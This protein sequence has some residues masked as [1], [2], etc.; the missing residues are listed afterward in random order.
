MQMPA[1]APQPKM[2]YQ[3]PEQAGSID[4]NGVQIEADKQFQIYIGQ[5]PRGSTEQELRETFQVCG[6]IKNVFLRAEQQFGFVN[7]LRKEGAMNAM[8]QR[9]FVI[10]GSKLTL[11]GFHKKLQIILR[12]IPPKIMDELKFQQ[13]LSRFLNKKHPDLFVYSQLQAAK[14]GASAYLH[15]ISKEDSI[16][17]FEA[18]KS[19]EFTRY[20]AKE[21]SLVNNLDNLIL[22][23]NDEVERR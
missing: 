20:A 4:I 14:Y 2:P 23:S 19:D 12:R 15:F 1:A 6:E 11:A 21:F 10:R 18:L 3:T 9:D 7:F 13:C 5:L 8:T 22:V 17:A 16:N